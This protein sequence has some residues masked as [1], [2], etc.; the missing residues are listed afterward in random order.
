MTILVMVLTVY[1]S[2]EIVPMMDVLIVN[3]M[4]KHVDD[5]SKMME[6]K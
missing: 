1:L 5:I 4:V 2:N 6:L 3:K